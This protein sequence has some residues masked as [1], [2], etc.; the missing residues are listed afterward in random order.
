[1]IGPGWL[2][3]YKGRAPRRHTLAYTRM[4]RRARTRAKSPAP[5][6]RV[7]NTEIVLF[8]HGPVEFPT[9]TAMPREPRARVVAL[10]AS[11]E[12][13]IAARWAWFRP[14]SVPCAVAC[15][16]MIAVMA[17][18]HYLAHQHDDLRSQPAS[19]SAVSVYT[20]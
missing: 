16:G 18:A 10:V 14:R 19:I 15:L 12:R 2:P 6:P 1:M 4:R 17:S 20:P 11:L 5:S 3:G 8:D 7:A 9:A 13:W